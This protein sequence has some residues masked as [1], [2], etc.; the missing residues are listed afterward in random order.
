MFLQVFHLISKS[1]KVMTIRF[2]STRSN[3]Y[4][5]HDNKS[6]P[7]HINESSLSDQ[8]LRNDTTCHAIISQYLRVSENSVFS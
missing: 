2:L 6:F 4:N 7:S 3:N 1:L 5:M 8:K